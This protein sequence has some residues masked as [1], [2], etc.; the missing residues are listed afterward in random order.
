VD[1][2]FY[3][4]STATST[5]YC[6][7]QYYV[8]SSPYW[9][10][11][12]YYYPTGTTFAYQYNG[13]VGTTYATFAAWKLAV[14]VTWDN[15]ST[16]QAIIF[17][18]PP[19]GN[20]HLAGTSQN[21]M[22]LAGVVLPQVP[23]D[24]DGD[25]RVIPYRG[26]DEA[27]YILPGSLTQ[28]FIDNNGNTLQ[29]AELPGTVKYKYGIAFPTNINFVTTIT[30]SFINVAT[31]QTMYTY[32][33]SVNKV[34]GVPLNGVETITL[35]NNLPVGSYR[36]NAV[37]NTMN[38]SSFMINYNVGL[39]GILVVPKG[40]TPCTVWPGDANNDGVD[41]FVDQ[42]VINSYIMNA[43][44]RPTWLNGPA[45]YN[46]AWE[47]QP[48]L[49]LT[50]VGQMCAPWATSDGCYIDAD[51]NGVVNNFDYLAVKI[52]WAR[53][54]GPKP[55][56]KSNPLTPDT[57]DMTQNYPNPFNPTTTL[58]VSTPEVSRVRLVV[59]DMLGREVATL[60]NGQVEIG[61]HQVVFDASRL[62]SGVYIATVTMTGDASGL[63]FSK[64]VRMT[65]SK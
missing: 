63:T 64:I 38:S 7:Y 29:Y 37:Y 39:L 14:P 27:C 65:L 50:W 28:D 31:G 32:Q 42:K 45:R 60:M 49:Y 12:V 6:I 13:T 22:T 24:I 16:Q 3:D 20:L 11:N 35:P 46:A 44:L 56:P 36:V 58:M 5:N 48:A 33:F 53:S 26:A 34:S 18:D 21:D 15:H 61:V 57:F 43:G 30:L 47:G 8:P 41:N 17:T 19:N 62:A 54:H 4:A 2:I 9:D 52:N 51:G 23:T 25:P 40:T 1:N 10:Y 59:T 55:A